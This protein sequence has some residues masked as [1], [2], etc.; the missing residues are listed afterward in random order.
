VGL[1]GCRWLGPRGEPAR[2]GLGGWGRR[3]TDHGDV[4]KP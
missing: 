4:L 1:G 3:V 2:V